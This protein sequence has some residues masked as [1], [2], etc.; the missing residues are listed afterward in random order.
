MDPDVDD[1]M[2]HGRDLLARRFGVDTRALAAFR[3]ALGLLVLADLLFRGRELT[4]FYTDAGVLPRDLHAE[5]TPTLARY[6][7]HTLTGSTAGQALLFL[8]GGCLAVALL[9]GYRTR[10]ATAGVVALHASMYARNTFLM[11]GGDGLLV[12]ALFLS[13]F[14]PLGERWS[15]DALRAGTGEDWTPR[16]RVTSMATVTL[17]SQLVVVYLA[18]AAF[19]AESDA[20]TSGT[21]VQ[22]V[23]ELEQFSVF[24]GPYLT[25][26]PELLAAIN[27][28]WVAMLVASPLLV[29]ATGWRRALVV[30]G[31]VVA[32]LGMLATM[33]LGLFPLVVTALLLLY[34]PPSVWDRFERRV[35]AGGAVPEP[36]RRTLEERPPAIDLPQLPPRVGHAG[37]VTVTAFLVVFLLAS[38]LW[39]AAV[40]GVVDTTQHEAVP[41]PDGYTWTLFAPDPPAETRWFVAPATLESGE[42][43][44][45]LDGSDVTFDP[46]ADAAGAYPSTLWH[47]YLSDARWADDDVQASLADHLCRRAGRYADTEVTEVAVYVLEQPVES[48]GGGPVE[49]TELVRYDCSASTAT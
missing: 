32:H 17:L 34:L 18:N 28:L 20:W 33:R 45:A 44:D 49:R 36:L 12:L 9:A 26:Y 22:Q 11:N 3:V 42:R 37:R 48:V 7:L 29:L 16:L 21:A 13:L 23:L 2:G 43:I 46:S 14:L 24:L 10:L 27:W 41:D 5:L 4:T 35:V 8:F 6:S 15:V 40:V 39:P 30:A 1:L 38:V 19:K 31:F 25:A 47:R